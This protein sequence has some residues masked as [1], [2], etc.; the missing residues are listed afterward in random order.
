MGGVPTEYLSWRW[1][2]YVNV[3]FAVVA[4]IGAVALITNQERAATAALDVPGSV[5]AVGGLVPIVY[6]LS[7]ASTKGWGSRHR[8]ALPAQGRLPAPEPVPMARG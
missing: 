7:E 5:L 1:C 6:G 3:A 8:P 4:L 2:L